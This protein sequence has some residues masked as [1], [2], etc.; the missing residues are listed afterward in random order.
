MDRHIN[1]IKT[2]C[3][4]TLTSAG[5]RGCGS[6]QR[7]NLDWTVGSSYSKCGLLSDGTGSFIK[8]KFSDLSPNL[9]N[10]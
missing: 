2:Q 8:C 1:Y 9:P 6:P 10:L 7:L 5:F 4:V 3:D